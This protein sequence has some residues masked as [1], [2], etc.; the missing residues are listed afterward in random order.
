MTTKKTNRRNLTVIHSELKGE[1]QLLPICPRCKQ[2][3]YPAPLTP[4]WAFCSQID[5]RGFPPLQIAFLQQ[6]EFLV[7]KEQPV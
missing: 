5:C 7:K 2:P 6:R 4:D 1:R 3:V